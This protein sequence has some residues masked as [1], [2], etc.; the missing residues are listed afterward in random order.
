MTI[1]WNLY[2]KRLKAERSTRAEAAK[3]CK[4]NFLERCLVKIIW[5]G[6]ILKQMVK[7]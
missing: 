1:D 3:V 7:R 6:Y 5:V 4:L 2:V